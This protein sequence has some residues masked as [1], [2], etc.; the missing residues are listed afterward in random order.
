MDRSLTRT[1]ADAGVVQTPHVDEIAR[2]SGRSSRG[3]IRA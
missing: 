3:T 2:G 1:F